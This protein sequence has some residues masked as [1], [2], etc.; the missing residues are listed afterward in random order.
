MKSKKNQ[1]YHRI[2][3]R[4]YFWQIFENGVFWAFFQ[5]L[6]I[7]FGLLEF[8]Y[9]KTDS[10]FVFRRPKY[11][12]PESFIQIGRGQQSKSAEIDLF[13][14]FMHSIKGILH[15]NR[16]LEVLVLL[17]YALVQA[18]HSWNSKSYY[19]FMMIFHQFLWL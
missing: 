6:R 17:G 14:R 12:N 11:I 15:Y 2:G 9:R 4:K 3:F 16:L 18:G 5:T 7:F 8:F 1:T 10:R 13:P 19:D